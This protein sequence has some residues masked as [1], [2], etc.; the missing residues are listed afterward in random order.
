VVSTDVRA[1]EKKR[2]KHKS[3]EKA[4]NIFWR[5]PSEKN[6]CTKNNF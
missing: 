4:K 6:D 3:M 2:E 1:K 5:G